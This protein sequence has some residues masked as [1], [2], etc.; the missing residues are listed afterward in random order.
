MNLQT[1]LHTRKIGGSQ[2]GDHE[3]FRLLG[4]KNPVRTSQEAHYFSATEPSQLMLYNIWGTR[5]GDYEECRLLG[6]ITQF[7]LHRRQDS[8]SEISVLTRGTQPNI[9]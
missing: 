7:L 6:Y 9:P 1:K 2:G 3:E 5:G 8:S 4:Y